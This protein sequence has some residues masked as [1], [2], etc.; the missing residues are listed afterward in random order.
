MVDNQVTGASNKL[1][2][3]ILILL[4][5]LGFITAFAGGF[6]LKD[7]LKKESV[8]TSGTTKPVII[9][10]NSGASASG[11]VIPNQPTI[12]VRPPS[13]DTPLPSSYKPGKYHPPSI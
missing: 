9:K 6:Y 11:S 3:I 5:I 8:L 2:K 13:D 10:E 1:Q 4:V 12:M 7:L